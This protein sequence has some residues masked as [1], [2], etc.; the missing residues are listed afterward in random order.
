MDNAVGISENMDD[1]LITILPNPS[2]GIFTLNI[3]SYIAS[4]LNLQVLDSR[5]SIVFEMENKDLPLHM[6]QQIDL[7]NLS[8]GI[9]FA[10]ILIDGRQVTRKLIKE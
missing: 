1:E 6:N 3:D 7:S 9:Y 10:R 4:V 8:D 2:E 5:G